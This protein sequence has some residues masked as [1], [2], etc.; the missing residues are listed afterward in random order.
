MMCQKIG[1]VWKLWFSDDFGN[2]QTVEHEI[3]HSA[4]CMAFIN[5]TTELN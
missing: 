4:L 2:T 3:F 5:R 1:N